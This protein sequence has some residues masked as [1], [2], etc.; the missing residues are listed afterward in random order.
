MI[1]MFSTRVPDASAGV[2]HVGI[3]ALRSFLRPVTSA[4]PR[5]ARLLQHARDERARSR[6]Y[7]YIPGWILPSSH[8]SCQVVV[9]CRG[10][11]VCVCTWGKKSRSVNFE[12]RR[13]ETQRLS[14]LCFTCHEHVSDGRR[15]FGERLVQLFWRGEGKCVKCVILK[16]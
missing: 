13:G 4:H 15:G 9:M 14:L 7:E 1:D 10:L 16:K 3:V 8:Q 6:T 12:Q 11:H 5:I 2:A